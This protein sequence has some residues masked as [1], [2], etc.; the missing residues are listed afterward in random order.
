MRIIINNNYLFLKKL[1]TAENDARE[2]ANVLARDY[3][4]TVNLQ[5]DVKR[6]DFLLAL[7]QLR[8]E[9]TKKDNHSPLH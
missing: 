2:V 8:K 3:G 6:S 9:L 1:K 5:I 4:Y 7:N